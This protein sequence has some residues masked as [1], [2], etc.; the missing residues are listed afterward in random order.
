MSA[1]ETTKYVPSFLDFSTL[2][3]RTDESPM[4]FGR[5]LDRVAKTPTRLFPPSLGGLTVGDSFQ[6]ALGKIPADLLGPGC[7]RRLLLQRSLQGWRQAA[8]GGNKDEE[9]QDG[10]KRTDKPA[11]IGAIKGNR[12]V[13][14]NK[15]S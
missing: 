11:P 3:R 14:E 2:K 9:Q 5:K 15:N 10:N 8:H 4:E 7:H 1:P 13:Y 6:P 12:P